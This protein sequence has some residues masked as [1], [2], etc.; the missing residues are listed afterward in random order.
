M[1]ILTQDERVSG[2]PRA[3]ARLAPTAR[4]A[5]ALLALVG[6]LVGSASVWAWGLDEHV[7]RL[8]VAERTRPA[9]LGPPGPDNTGVPAG[10]VL[11]PYVGD[12]VVKTPGAVYDSLDIHGFV[13][14]KARNVTIRR[15]IVRGGPAS[16][17]TG[18]IKVTDPAAT[19]FLLEDSELVPS[20]PS[21]FVDGIH[22]ANFT[23]RRVEARGAVDLVKVFGDHV[24]VERSWLH[25]ARDFDA[26][27]SHDGGPT[28]N[29]GV[30]VLAGRDIALV[31]NTIAGASNAAVQVTQDVG[32]VADLRLEGNWLDGGGCT[33]NLA[34]K[35]QRTMGAVLVRDNVFGPSARHAGCHLLASRG[36]ALS[37]GE[38][39]TSTG[40][41]V[42]VQWTD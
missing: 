21:V 17:S 41:P 20:E 42:A 4:P 33:V 35:P 1:P 36:T 40:P 24:L 16:V 23:L 28:H 29:D 6:V 9:P 30:Q 31:E 12:L 25:G 2:V 27:P 32:A 8:T 19:G 26:D 22:G 37:V 5:V 34:K 15:S 14:I 10:T 13:R 38:N 11:T 18:L 39:R 3:V 7:R